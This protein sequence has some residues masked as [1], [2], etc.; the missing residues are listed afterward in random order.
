MASVF[1]AEDTVLGRNVAVKRLHAAPDT[2]FGR[3]IRREARLGAG[4]RH[5]NLVTVFD[6]AADEAALLLVMEYVAGETLADALKR[7]PMAPDRALPI[8]R[9]IAEAL[10]H[11]HEHGVVHRDVKPANVLLGERGVAKLTDLG[12]ATS[13]E[14]TQITRT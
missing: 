10:D 3:R 4:A 12:V 11:L 9:Q 6:V 14:A 1:L 8:L 2:E 5:P 7:G 13:A